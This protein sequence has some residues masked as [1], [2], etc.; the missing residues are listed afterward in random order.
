MRYLEVFGVLGGIWRLHYVRDCRM[1]QL[2]PDVGTTV[3]HTKIGPLFVYDSPVWGGVPDY[4]R[5]EFQRVQNI[6]L[7]IIDVPVDTL[8]AVKQRSTPI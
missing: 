4:L 6:S 3:Y 5:N 7:D 1:A 8:P 2:P